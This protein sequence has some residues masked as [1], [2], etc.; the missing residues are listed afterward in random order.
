MARNRHGTRFHG[1]PLAEQLRAAR[2]L[3]R[4]FI[5]TSDEA[6]PVIGLLKV[7][8]ANIN[9]ARSLAQPQ[10]GRPINTAL[11]IR[12]LDALEDARVPLR[13]HA[14]A[15]AVE[16]LSHLPAPHKMPAATARAVLRRLVDLR[17][18]IQR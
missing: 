13:V 12:A 6:D 5:V 3:H 4:P 10:R 8:I 17:R 15:K 16:V 9:V 14:S 2:R 1:L 18:Q 7:V 11:L